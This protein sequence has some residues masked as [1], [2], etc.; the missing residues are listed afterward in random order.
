M[1]IA[2]QKNPVDRIDYFT[3][4][5]TTDNAQQALKQMETVLHKIDP[6]HLFRIQ[7]PG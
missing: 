6:S 7:F 3:A 1:I 2:Y 5:L 4:R